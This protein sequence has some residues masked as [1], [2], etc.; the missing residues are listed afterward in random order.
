MVISVSVRSASSFFTFADMILNRLD[1]NPIHSLNIELQS[2]KCDLMLSVTWLWSDG[3]EES[4]W[5]RA[6]DRGRE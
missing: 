2:S 3:E 6:R 1:W 5:D 4:I